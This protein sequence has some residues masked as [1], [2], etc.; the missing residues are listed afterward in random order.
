MPASLACLSWLHSLPAS[1]GCIPCLQPLP[2]SLALPA[3]VCSPCLPPLVAFQSLAC[4]LSFLPIQPASLACL[5]PCLPCLLACLSCLHS[6]L[7]CLP[8]LPVLPC[9]CPLAPFP[10]HL[11]PFFLSSSSQTLAPASSLARASTL[12]PDPTQYYCLKF[13]CVAPLALLCAS[14]LSQHRA[15]SAFNEVGTC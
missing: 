10:L 14:L 3:L 12:V 7:A 2:A 11:S 4:R 5:L 6:T 9:I 13:G 8:C 15:E 1:L